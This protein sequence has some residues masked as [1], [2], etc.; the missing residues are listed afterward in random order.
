MMEMMN[1]IVTENRGGHLNFSENPDPTEALESPK[2]RLPLISALC[3][4]S[5]DGMEPEH[6]KPKSRRI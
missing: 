2:S 3:E 6:P 4:R 1:Q 5:V